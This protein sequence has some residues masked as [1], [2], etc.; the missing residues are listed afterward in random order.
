MFENK[1]IKKSIDDQ[2]LEILE[3]MEK[4]TK[5]ASSLARDYFPMVCFD[6]RSSVRFCMMLYAE[7]HGKPHK[8]AAQFGL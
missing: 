8:S 6:L 5:D 4:S 1:I 2:K 7:F 3:A